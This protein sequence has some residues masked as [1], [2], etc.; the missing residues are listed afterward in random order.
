MQPNI[1]EKFSNINCA[2]ALFECEC[3]GGHYLEV[4]RD[5]TDKELWIEFN[6]TCPSFW[7]LLRNFR[8]LGKAYFSSMLLR[9]SDVV[10]LKEMIDQYLE[11]TKDKS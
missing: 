11:D 8:Y 5:K 1:D 3:R 7:Q 9:R 4:I 2:T 6:D 10:K